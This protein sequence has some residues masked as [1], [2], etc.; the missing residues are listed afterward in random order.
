MI[1][2]SNVAQA[3]RV[4]DSARLAFARYDMTLEASPLGD[5]PTNTI[6]AAISGGNPKTVARVTPTTG[7]MVNWHISPIP[8]ALGILMTP[9][10]SLKLIA[11][12]IPN[13][14]IC[15]KGT[16]RSF[17]SKLPHWVKSDG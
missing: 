16:I 4:T 17:R 14:M 6:P 13:M 2:A 10:K 9:K 5:D 7:I 15:N 11:V 12:P 8:T 3:V 1:G